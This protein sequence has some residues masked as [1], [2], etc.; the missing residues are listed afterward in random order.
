MAKTVEL[1]DRAYEIISSELW[2]SLEAIR[3]H[4]GFR[5][6]EDKAFWKEIAEEFEV[7][8]DDYEDVP[9]EDDLED[10]AE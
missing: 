1:S 4:D 5:D 8:W 2:Q 7:D 6:R 3:K 9:T 10:L